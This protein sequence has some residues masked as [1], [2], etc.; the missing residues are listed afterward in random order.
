[1]HLAG[2]THDLKK[3]SSPLDYYEA[4]FELTQKL[5]D[6]FLSSK[7]SNFIFMS[8]VKSVADEVTGIL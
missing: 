8:T 5:F 4:N 2:K 7:S 6:A 3:V 1:M